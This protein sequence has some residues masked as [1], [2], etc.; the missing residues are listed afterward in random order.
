MKKALLLLF[1]VAAFSYSAFSQTGTISCIAYKENF[2]T[3][4]TWGTW[5]D[6][7]K[8][9]SD[10]GRSNPKIRIT[11]NGK[12]DDGVTTYRVEIIVDGTVSADFSVTY[13]ADKT[14]QVRKD[15]N[16]EYANCYVDKVG[17]YIYTQKVSLKSLS[18]DPNDW[19]DNKDSQM[20]FFLFSADKAIVVK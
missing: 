13:D 9:Y 18:D 6:K 7:W 4:G 15:W 12:N 1:F 8:S 19:K 16:D 2:R 17:D 5:P 14:T 20:Y 3:S 11:N 10:E